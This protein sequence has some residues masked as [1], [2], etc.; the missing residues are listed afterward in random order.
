MFVTTGLNDPRVQYWEPAKWVAKLRA[1]PTSDKPIVLRTEMGAGHGG[2]SGRYDA[3]RD[4]ATVLAFVC[5]I[6]R[7]RR[8]KADRSRASRSAPTTALA[9]E[10]ELRREPTARPRARRGR[11]VPSASAVRRHDAQ[12]RDLGAVRRA[13]ARRVRVPALQLP[14][15]RGQ[16]REPTPTARPSRST[17]SPRSTAD[18]RARSRGAPIV[19]RR[20]VVRRRHGA[21]GRRRPR[22]R[23][24]SRSRRRCGSGRP[25]AARRTTRARSI[26][27]SPST[28]SSARRRRRT[29]SRGVDRDT[30]VAV[31]AGREP[32]LRGSHRP[33]R[34]RDAGR[35][36]PRSRH[37]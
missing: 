27:C 14:R 17:S 8:V 28:T 11:A 2:P 33:R 21:D 20:L 12:P 29:R 9:L 37:R 24:G 18:G 25:F 5:S 3:W 23:G 16:R 6:G 1:T 22:S 30:T 31:V 34:H 13:P 26:S 35:C 19:A 7:R 4:E 36:R 32:L 15:R 10:A